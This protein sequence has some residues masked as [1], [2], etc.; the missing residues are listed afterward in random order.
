MDLDLWLRR[1]WEEGNSPRVCKCICTAANPLGSVGESTCSR[2][3]HFPKEGDYYKRV[4][5]WR[6]RCAV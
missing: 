3:P 6:V 2:I 4:E 5:R 1:R